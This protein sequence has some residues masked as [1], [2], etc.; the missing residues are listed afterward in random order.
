MF[1]SVVKHLSTRK[2]ATVKSVRF[3]AAQPHQW[4]NKN[5]SR[6]ICF[7]SLEGKT[8]FG[9]PV[10]GSSGITQAKLVD[11][12][13]RVTDKKVEVHKLLAPLVPTEII[14]VGLNYQKHAAESKLPIP[15]YPVVF[16]KNLNAVQNPGDNIV[17]P[18]VALDPP[19]VD[20]E[21]EL[22]VVIGKAAKNV[23]A[24]KALDYVLG[25][26]CA[27]DVSARLWQLQRGGSQWSFSKGFDTFCP[28]GPVLVSPSVIPDPNKLKISTVLNGEVVQDSNTSDMIFNVPKIIEFLSQSTTLLPG[29]VIITGTPEGVGMARKPPKWL[30]HGDVVTIEI[31]KIGKLTNPV[32]N[33]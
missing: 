15:Q 32:V 20:Y 27:N 22:A 2:V 29:T 18:K 4:A 23:S 13:G 9:E 16:Y 25:Y 30:K 26:T 1:A 5:W 24:A 3:M 33:E 11:D 12:N 7:K 31:E 17:I 21:C 10:Y 14:C 8:S 19:E 28:L 6:I